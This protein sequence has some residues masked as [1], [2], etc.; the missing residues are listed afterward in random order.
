[1]IKTREDMISGNDTSGNTRT[2]VPTLPV[3]P[4][5]SE[6]MTA[7][8][9]QCRISYRPPQPHPKCQSCGKTTFVSD[10]DAKN[11]LTTRPLDAVPMRPYHDNQCQRWH[12][13]S[14]DAT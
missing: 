8:A 9:R 3:R 1:M 2:I 6:D 7:V 14:K 5:R 11:F 4:P 10:A 13:T 12:L